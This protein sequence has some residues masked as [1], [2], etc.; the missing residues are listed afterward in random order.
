LYF[1]LRGFVKDGVHAS[2]SRPRLHELYYRLSC[3]MLVRF[4][5]LSA[6]MLKALINPLEYEAT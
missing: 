2:K 4:E 3:F 1:S 5:V 6:V